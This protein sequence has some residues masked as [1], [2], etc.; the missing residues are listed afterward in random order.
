MTGRE[1]DSSCGVSWMLSVD[2]LWLGAIPG[3]DVV[4]GSAPFGFRWA[5]GGSEVLDVVDMG[6]PGGSDFSTLGTR[7][8]CGAARDV[9][10]SSGSSGT[11]LRG[12]SGSAVGALD[13]GASVLCAC[14]RFLLDA[15]IFA[16]S[17]SRLRFMWY[18]RLELYSTGRGRRCLCQNLPEETR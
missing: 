6:E 9:G 4:A 17:S 11:G 2:S 18:S 3:A 15:A 1:A 13:D 16:C 5:N 7:G 12:V 14:G 10:F 8:V